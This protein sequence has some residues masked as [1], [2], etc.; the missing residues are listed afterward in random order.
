MPRMRRQCLSL[1]AMVVAFAA[2]VAT[3]SAQSYP[4]RPVRL[5]VPAAAGGPS[6]IMARIIAQ[7]LA[8]AWGQQFIVENMPTGAGNVGVGMVAKSPPDG[9][10]ILTPTSAIIVN[11][12]LY[13]KL[14]YDTVRDFAAVT[15]AAASPHVLTVT[16]SLP[17]RNVQELIA[18]VKA[19]PGKYSYASPGAGTTGQLS[20]ELFKLS[21]GL[22]LLHVP[23]N[24]ASPA[25]TSTIGGHTPI[26]FCALP[27]ATSNIKDGKLRALAVTSGK[28]VQALPDVPTMAE[29]GF[30]DQES[31]FVQA[32]LAPAGTPREIVDLWYREIA[33]VVGLPEVKDR[34]TAIGFEAVANTPDEFGAWLKAEIVRWDRV[35]RDAG[36]KKI[37]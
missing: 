5:I 35:I 37:D 30:A 1:A 31:L 22:D 34:L 29:A 8:E 7:K 9:Y 36:I 14:S 3:A 12:S 33:R 16:P 15:L 28:R 32:I 21:L 18:L 11:P 23:F 26:L 25:I 20:G 4:T 10:T 27:A 19:N 17:A 24:G 2:T 13:A 6:D